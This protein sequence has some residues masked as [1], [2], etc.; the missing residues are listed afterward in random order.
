MKKLHKFRCLIATFC[1]GLSAA[2]ALAQTS[3][4]A[5]DSIP[6]PLNFTDLVDLSD[7]AQMVIRAQIRRQILVPSERA[8]GLRQGFARLYIEARTLALVSGDVPI[9]ESLRYLVD[10]PLTSR[11]KV[12]KLKK[13]QVLL[14]ARTSNAQRGE[15]QLTGV[16]GQQPYS[17]ELEQRLRPV[18]AE[19]AKPD[20]PATVTGVRDALSVA[21]NL[22]G[23]SETQIF[24]RT[25]DNSPVSIS[26][27]RR[28]QQ[29]PFWGVSWGEIID[30]AATAPRPQTIEWYR[31][32][33]ALP[34]SLPSEANLSRDV[35]ARAQAERDY[36]FVMG[37]L[38]PCV[39][40]LPIS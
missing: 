29:D 7:A 30:Q 13:K 39:R 25:Q 35:E 34:Q 19:L 27:L 20:S 21:G 26:V 23:E 28:P 38:G 12:P 32:A 16:H 8:P 24:L 17:P 14:F 1:L 4:N 40:N 5:V 31:L 2:P 15:V 11:G 37:A 9:G 18:L 22:A 36:R 6:E 33:C 10:V 3:G